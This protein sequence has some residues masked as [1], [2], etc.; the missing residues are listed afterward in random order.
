MSELISEFV[1]S[2]VF[3]IGI[4]LVT[5]YA[6]AQ[7]Y[8]RTGSPLLNPLVLSMFMIIAL[9]L[10]FHIS[11]DDYNN[12][13][14]FISFFLGPATVILAVPLYRKISLLKE[15]VIPIIAGISIGSAA[16]ITSIIVM[17]KMF[18]LDEILSVSLI[19]KSVTTPI[20]IEISNQLGG[21]PSVTVAAIVFTGIAGVLLGPMVCKLFR[22]E[23]K[24]AL[25]V[26]IGTSSHALGTT[27]AVEL[28]ETE[29]AMSGL[30]IGIAGLITVFL[31]PLL[32]KLLM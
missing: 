27:K 19:P 3:G 14:Q 30:A 32:A 21:L 1:Q 15:N 13:G 23:D 20:G 28:G 10:S 8:K 31:A 9:L 25:G 2:P 6:G 18:G 16:G 22:I 7:I 11:F 5:F 29:G 26:A 12:G 24:V 17:C 4:S